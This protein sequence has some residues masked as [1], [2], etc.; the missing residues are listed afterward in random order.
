MRQL[1]AHFC[2]RPGQIIRANLARISNFGPSWS[3]VPGMK[4][5]DQLGPHFNFCPTWAEVSDAKTVTF[6]VTINFCST[7]TEVDHRKGSQLGN[8]FE[9]PGSLGNG[10]QLGH[11][12][13][14]AMMAR[15][16]LKRN[17]RKLWPTWTQLTSGQVDQ[18]LAANDPLKKVTNLVT[19]LLQ[20]K[21]SWSWSPFTSSQLGMKS[22]CFNL[23]S[24]KAQVNS[25]QIE[26]NYL[27][28][29]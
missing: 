4:N 29:T 6:M 26:L 1:G 14:L 11:N 21:F 18:K 12:L 25:V 23:W 17:H 16:W 2:L 5:V 13:L 24:T 10:V 27:S 22:P 15:S 9:S 20:D 28:D 7:W 19:F 3:E 8:L